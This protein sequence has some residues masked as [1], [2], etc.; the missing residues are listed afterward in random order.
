M[1]M[2]RWREENVFTSTQSVDEWM[3]KMVDYTTD[4]ILFSLN[5]KE[6]LRHQRTW[7]NLEDIVQSETGQT[8]K[9]KHCM[10]QFRK[11]TR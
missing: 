1:H 4:G 10:T 8:Q 2:K 6:L 5:R 7:V 11:Q 9:A 3:N